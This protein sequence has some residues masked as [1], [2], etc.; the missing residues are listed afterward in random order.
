MNRPPLE[1]ADIDEFARSFSDRRPAACVTLE[2]CEPAREAAIIANGIPALIT[3]S[4]PSSCLLH[5][6]I[7]YARE[8][9]FSL[10]C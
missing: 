7:D 10:N 1:V 9:R 4:D 8:K 6:S 5:L 2:D 3:P